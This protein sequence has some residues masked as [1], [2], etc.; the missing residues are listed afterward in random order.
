MNYS[1]IQYDNEYCNIYYS[2]N[3]IEYLIFSTELEP[4]IF[5]ILFFVYLFEINFR[6]IHKK[7]LFVPKLDKYSLEKANIWWE[8]KL[9]NIIHALVVGPLALYTLLN[10]FNMLKIFNSLQDYDYPVL[11]ETI[12]TI[13]ESTFCPIL[14]TYTIGFFIWDLM[15]YYQTENFTSLMVLHHLISIIVWP[16]AL[17][18]GLANFFLLHFMASELST[19]FIHIRWY[20]RMKYGKNLYWL[21]TTLLFI[22]LFIIVRILV[23]PHLMLGLYSA[24]IWKHNELNIGLRILA[25]STLYL[26]SML[27]ILWLFYIIKMCVKFI[28]K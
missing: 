20:F 2:N 23:I 18:N 21:L 12:L 10:D 26:P 24:Q 16:I 9:I 27:N 22:I 28:W 6:F 13:P 7:F 5:R 4:I 25:T 14:T 1:L 3:I 15:H 8:I 19:P 11:Y 17:Y